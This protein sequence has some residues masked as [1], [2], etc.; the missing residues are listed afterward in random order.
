MLKEVNISSREA[1]TLFLGCDKDPLIAAK[2]PPSPNVAIVIPYLKEDFGRIV[3]NFLEWKNRNLSPCSDEF[4]FLNER[5]R[6]ELLLV[7][8]KNEDE[9]GSGNSERA[10]LRNTLRN[11]NSFFSPCFS[12]VKVISDI[13]N[14]ALTTCHNVRDFLRAPVFQ[15]YSHMFMMPISIEP[16]RAGWGSKILAETL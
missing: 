2:F 9:G 10:A 16:L 11:L 4:G 1:D 12:E 14:T 3:K 5:G 13:E 6:M 7:E 8:L 15:Q